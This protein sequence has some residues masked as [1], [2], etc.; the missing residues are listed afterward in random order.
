MKAAEDSIA[1]TA[2][3]G[4]RGKDGLNMTVGDRTSW[5]GQL[6]KDNRDRIARTG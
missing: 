6:G 2:R 4:K 1:R 5:T 3:T